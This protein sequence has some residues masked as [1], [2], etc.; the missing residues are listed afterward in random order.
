MSLSE[1]MLE[2]A[3]E[4]DAFVA[5]EMLTQEL[6]QQALQS[7]VR[8]I[9]RLCKA[10]E[11]KSVVP[12]S[13]FDP[14]SD[15][16]SIEGVNASDLA[17]TQRALQRLQQRHQR[18]GKTTDMEENLIDSMCLCVDGPE[19]GTSVFCPPGMQEGQSMKVGKYVYILQGNKLHVS[20]EP[21]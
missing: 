3:D 16:A 9:R 11:D 2:L 1:A 4:M 7:W 8:Q 6:T 20:V 15:P 21:G 5:K 18:V 14:R 19:E 10:A 12:F 13:P 17:A